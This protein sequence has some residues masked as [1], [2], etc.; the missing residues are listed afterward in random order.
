MVI[1]I[2]M[3]IYYFK[4][5]CYNLFQIQ[6]RK[7]L[8]IYTEAIME[9]QITS[10]LGFGCMRLPVL[11]NEKLAGMLSLRDLARKRIY[12]AEIGHIIYDICNKNN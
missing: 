7:T 10:R 3:L 4:Y 1:F 11:E 2:Q 6:L 9:K 12:I 8:I 5:M